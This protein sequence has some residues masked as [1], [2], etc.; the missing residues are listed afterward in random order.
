MT[1]SIRYADDTC[2]P[3][4]WML[5]QHPFDF[6]R[7]HQSRPMLDDFRFATHEPEKVVVILISKIAGMEPPVSYVPGGQLRVMPVT[8][9]HTPSADDHL[10]NLPGPRNWT[11]DFVDQ[12]N[13]HAS[14]GPADRPDFFSAVWGIHAAN[15]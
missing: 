4:R 15:L 5:I 8:C 2:L 11:T 1:E 9:G 14:D 12:R 6:D 13:F 3:D 10:A 7:R